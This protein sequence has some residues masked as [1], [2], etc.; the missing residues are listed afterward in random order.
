MSCLRPSLLLQ[1]TQKKPT[2]STGDIGFK[3]SATR[4]LK[5]NGKEAISARKLKDIVLNK[6]KNL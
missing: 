6:E 3:Q 5:Y 1:Q 4:K 2:Y